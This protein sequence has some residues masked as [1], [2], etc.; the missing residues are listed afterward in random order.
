V[1]GSR[2][3]RLRVK[4]SPVGFAPAN[5]VPSFD[6]LRE[7]FAKRYLRTVFAG[8]ERDLEALDGWLEGADNAGPRL[9]LLAAPAAAAGKSA[10]VTRWVEQRRQKSS[11]AV[12]FI[13]ISAQFNSNQQDIVLPAI[14]VELA[15]VLQV[16][17]RL[18]PVFS[19]S[20]CHEA[21]AALFNQFARSPRD[22]LLVVDGVDETRLAGWNIGPRLLPA[23]P[24]PGLKILVTARPLAGDDGP[25]GWRHR[26][27]WSK[28]AE[29]SEF[30]IDKLSHR[31]IA[32][33]V[34]EL[35]AGAGADGVNEANLAQLVYRL[36]DR[37]DPL[38]AEL[39][40]AEIQYQLR[41]GGDGKSLIGRLQARR[42]GLSGY[43]NNWM[44]NAALHSAPRDWQKPFCFCSRRRSVR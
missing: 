18:P 29:V 13:P 27:G 16:N 15:R 40:A 23:S 7:A 41:S 14:A 20:A 8:R 11:A 37:G 36:T 24:P 28:P 22:C 30:Q 5:A 38:L 34:H 1:L 12:I 32:E 26:L 19:A 33:L 17:P 3:L 2:A 39:Y 9:S 25:A 10:L 44:A 35:L 4:W 43:F 6:A 21:I 31:D 42:A